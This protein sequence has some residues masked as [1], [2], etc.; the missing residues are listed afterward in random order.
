MGNFITSKLVFVIGIS[1]RKELR[2][3]SLDKVRIKIREEKDERKNRQSDQN[4]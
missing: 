4:W 1:D 3:L 2:K